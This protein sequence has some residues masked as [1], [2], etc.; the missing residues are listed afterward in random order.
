MR[1]RVHV[2]S[3]TRGENATLLQK[4]KGGGEWMNQT[5]IKRPVH[6]DPQKRE[7]TQI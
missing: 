3:F 6:A 5:C 2:A 7:N 1:A 4:K